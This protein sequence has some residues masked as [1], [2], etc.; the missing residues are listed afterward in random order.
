[1]L[2]KNTNQTK[3]NSTTVI[4][5]IV[6]QKYIHNIMKLMNSVR[7]YLGNSDL[8]I[9]VGGLADF[10]SENPDLNKANQFMYYSVINNALQSLPQRLHNISFVSSKK[11]T[12]KGDYLHFDSESAQILGHRY[13]I[14]LAQLS[15]NL[16]NEEF[17][18][19]THIAKT[20]KIKSTQAIS[21]TKSFVAF[22][23]VFVSCLCWFVLLCYQTC[24]CVFFCLIVNCKL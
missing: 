23:V 7:Y 15:G 19:L 11:L 14:K 20:L 12:H 10:L 13:A 6:C 22:C 4:E 5:L 1:M 16:T 18:R 2:N 3:L 8:L 17:N 24:N 9:L 21:K